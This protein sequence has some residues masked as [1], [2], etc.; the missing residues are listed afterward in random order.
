MDQAFVGKTYCW[1]IFCQYS[2]KWHNTYA[3]CYVHYNYIYIYIFNIIKISCYSYTCWPTQAIMRLDYKGN[4]CKNI[5]S[6]KWTR[7]LTAMCK[8]SK[9]FLTLFFC[10]CKTCL[11]M[12]IRVHNQTYEWHLSCEFHDYNNNEGCPKVL[13]GNVHVALSLKQQRAHNFKITK[14]QSHFTFITSDIT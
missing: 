3:F 12:V 13:W 4:V 5:H 11:T 9:Y 6:K 10:C 14:C 2:T 8:N 1:E 7:S